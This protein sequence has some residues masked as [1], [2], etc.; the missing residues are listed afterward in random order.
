MKLKHIEESR[1]ILNDLHKRVPLKRMETLRQHGVTSTYQHSLNVAM[2]SL[3]MAEKLAIRFDLES[4]LQGAMLH[5]FY[6]YD[7]HDKDPNHRWH[8]FRHP[9]RALMQ[10]LKYIDL[11]SNSQNIIASHMWPLTFR[12]LPKCREAWLVCMADKGCAVIESINLAKRIE[13]NTIKINSAQTA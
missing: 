6:G 9:D 11:S 7:W 8:G 2:V 5:D 10:S 3:W 13:L 4:L 12:H 1:R